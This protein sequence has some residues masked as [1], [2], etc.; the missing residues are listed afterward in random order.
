VKQFSFILEFD[1]NSTSA[2]CEE[3]RRRST[4]R[5]SGK[6]ICTSSTQNKTPSIRVNFDY[7]FPIGFV[8][9]IEGQFSGKLVLFLLTEAGETL[10]LH[11]YKI[12]GE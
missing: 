8:P 12:L 3:G 5:S 4:W 6:N 1:R 10:Y 2:Y 9:S 7:G 11:E